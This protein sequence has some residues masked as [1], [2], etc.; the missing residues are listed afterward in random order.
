METSVFSETPTDVL[1]HAYLDPRV[2]FLVRLRE[3]AENG[4]KMVFLS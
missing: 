2:A 4:P 3:M 1:R